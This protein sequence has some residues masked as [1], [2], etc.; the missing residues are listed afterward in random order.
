MC[1]NILPK[2][3]YWYHKSQK[4]VVSGGDYGGLA[5]QVGCYVEVALLVLSPRGV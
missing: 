1:R 4:R 2:G 3:A 5:A